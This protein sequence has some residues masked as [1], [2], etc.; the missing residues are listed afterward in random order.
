MDSKLTICIA[1]LLA[2]L[3]GISCRSEDFQFESSPPEETLTPDSNAA[4]LLF[5]ISLNDGSIDNV[6]DQANCFTV[7]LPVDVTIE[8]NTL[9]IED[10][11]D[12]DALETLAE[13]ADEGLNALELVYPVTLIDREYEE[14]IVA[15]AD[16]LAQQ[17]ESCLGDNVVDE[18]IECVD[19]VYPITVFLFNATT[20]LFDSVS[21]QDD[22]MMNSFIS[23][24]NEEQIVNLQFPIN[25]VLSDGTQMEMSSQE[26]L[27][28]FIESNIDGCDE[29]D[30]NDLDD[31]DCNDCTEQELNQAFADCSDLRIE[32]FIVTGDQLQNQYTTF[33]FNFREDGH[34]IVANTDETYFGTWSAEG[35]RNEIQTTIAIPNLPEFSET[36]RLNEIFSF[37][38]TENVKFLLDGNTLQFRNFC[39]N[40]TPTGNLPLNVSSV[41][42]SDNWRVDSYFDGTS[43]ETPR[44]TDFSIGFNTDGTSV[45][46]ATNGTNTGGFWTV[47]QGNTA[48]DLNFGDN[49]PFDE[50]NKDWKLNF[51]SNTR[52]ELT[53]IGTGPTFAKLILV[54]L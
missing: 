18:D 40:G 30:D 53:E 39:N 6:L 10:E 47:E 31:D 28:A 29:D 11:S 13:D 33:S 48:L 26:N 3:L 42:V 7:K 2:C 15:S 8:G 52:I 54:K 14:I 27:E 22:G 36:W 12:F 20:E 35:A 41:L 17:A 43:D 34:L 5:R 21:I 32:K 50:L 38:G 25:V 51:I 46:V 4:D 1:L 9:T 49:Q 24:L 37:S 19:F 16:A 23:Q 44:F 45:V